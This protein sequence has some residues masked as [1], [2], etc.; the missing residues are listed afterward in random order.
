MSP[1]IKLYDA[2]KRMKAHRF[3]DSIHFTFL[4]YNDTNGSTD[5]FQ[6]GH[7]CTVKKGLS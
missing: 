5:G 2:L 4:S 1:T 7:K 3:R 6:A